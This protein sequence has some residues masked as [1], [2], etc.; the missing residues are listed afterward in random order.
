MFCS[1]CGAEAASKANFG[2]R[3]G[4]GTVIRC[5]F[6]IHKVFKLDNLPLESPL[7]AGVI[8]LAGKYSGFILQGLDHGWNS[9]F[10]KAFYEL[11]PRNQMCYF[12]FCIGNQ[13]KHK[14]VENFSYLASLKEQYAFFPWKGCLNIKFQEELQKQCYLF[15][16]VWGR[17]AVIQFRTQT[18]VLMKKRSLLTTSTVDLIT[19][20]FYFF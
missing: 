17:I 19:A 18:A 20:K 7:Q 10:S 4:Q 9:T 16:Q 11:S 8:D 14:K 15:T 1:S 5:R 13:T 12:S 2:V 3:F 6:V